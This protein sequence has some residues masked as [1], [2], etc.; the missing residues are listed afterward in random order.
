MELERRLSARKIIGTMKMMSAR[1]EFYSGRGANISDLDSKRLEYIYQFIKKEHG[2]KAGENFIQ[3]VADIPVLSATD[4]LNT[5]YRLDSNN[6]RWDKSLLGNEKGIDIGT[7]YGDGRREDIG[8]ATIVN[9]FG[10]SY[11]RDETDC[12]RGEFLRK[13]GINQDKYSENKYSEKDF[14]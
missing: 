2:E 7:D 13:H 9:I 11:D 1:P 4:F 14:Y 6:W 5:L 10:G 12:I 8:F 3:M